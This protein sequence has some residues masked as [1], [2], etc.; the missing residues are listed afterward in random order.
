M[1]RTIDIILIAVMLVAA[2]VTYKIKHDAEKQVVEIKKIQR[3]I[4][5]E[6]DTINLLKADWSLMTQ[7][8]RLQRL[9]DIYQAQLKLQ[10]VDVTQIGLFDDIPMKQADDIEKLIGGSADLVA[11][12]DSMSTGSI[13]QSA[14]APMRIV[15]PGVRP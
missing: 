7:P 10:P 5:F 14:A 4:A 3:Q 13:V 1:M 11:S 2:T 8:N 6:K 15:V 9:S 12:V